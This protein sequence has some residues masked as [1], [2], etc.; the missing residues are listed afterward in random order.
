M[1]FHP[2]E[3]AV[4]A[5]TT[6]MEHVDNFAGA[7]VVARVDGAYGAACYG[8]EEFPF[9]VTWGNLSEPTIETVKCLRRIRL[10]N[11]HYPHH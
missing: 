6:M 11:V 2:T 8:M 10:T 3:A 7:V 4:S 5:L 1:G 9:S